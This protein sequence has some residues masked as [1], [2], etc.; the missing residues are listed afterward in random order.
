M[1]IFEMCL[2]NNAAQISGLSVLLRFLD[3][4]KILAAGM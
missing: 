2:R 3:F 4:F 1:R